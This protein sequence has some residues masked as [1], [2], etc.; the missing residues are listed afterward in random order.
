M[1][2]SKSTG[3]SAAC[4]SV[5]TRENASA[6]PDHVAGLCHPLPGHQIAPWRP[7]RAFACHWRTTRAVTLFPG[8]RS[9]RAPIGN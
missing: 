7:L 3:K 6:R 8:K 1:T 5:R 4:K 2:A 9:I